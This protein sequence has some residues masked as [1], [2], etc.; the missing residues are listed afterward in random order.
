M[1]H[2]LDL[3]LTLASPGEHCCLALSWPSNN[4]NKSWFQSFVVFFKSP[5]S[6][7]H[8]R[9]GVMERG[10]VPADEWLWHRGFDPGRAEAAAP[11]GQGSD[12]EQP[13]LRR[14]PPG[15][16]AAAVRHRGP[17][18]WWGSKKKS[19][20]GLKIRPKKCSRIIVAPKVNWRATVCLRLIGLARSPGNDHAT[21]MHAMQC[22][23]IAVWNCWVQHLKSSFCLIYCGWNHNCCVWSKVWITPS[24]SF[25]TS[26]EK[27]RKTKVDSTLHCWV[28]FYW[29]YRSWLATTEISF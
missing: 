26:S 3:F 13:D 9:P 29:N 19:F 11:C 2:F 4:W 20:K 18:I 23:R 25:S 7:D 8:L 15:P 24:P 12:H 22:T 28:L 6:S 5:V 21:H 10:A 14:H 17:G 1:R 16:R 27:Q